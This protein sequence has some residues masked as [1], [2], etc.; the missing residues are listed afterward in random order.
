[1]DIN[2]A[3][4][5]LL[6]DNL[7]YGQFDGYLELLTANYALNI[8]DESGSTVVA[9]FTAPLADLNLYGESLTV[10][11]SGFLDPSVNSNGPEF[12]LLA[13]KADGTALMLTNTSGVDDQAIEP[14]S[15]KIYPNPA[16]ESVNIS[17]KL[18]SKE[19]VSVSITDI[20][21]R[22]VKNIGFGMKN[23]GVYEEKIAVDDLIPGMYMISIL[24][25]GDDVAKKLFIR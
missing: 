3:S 22:V 12:G 1:V 11:A 20:S 4:A 21:G 24:T 16:F 14:S 10:L 2:E 18:K 6:V 5:G 19:M 23:A 9:T 13:V 17:Y 7:S 15:F 25:S 8:T